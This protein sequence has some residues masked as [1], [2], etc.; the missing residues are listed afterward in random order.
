MSILNDWQC[1][2][3]QESSLDYGVKV[4]GKTIKNGLKEVKEFMI[5]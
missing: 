2:N 4:A 1:G 5:Q 3:K